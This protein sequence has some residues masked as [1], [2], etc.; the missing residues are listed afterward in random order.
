M[1]SPREGGKAGRLQA[2]KI[3][4]M[5]RGGHYVPG[6]PRPGIKGGVCPVIPDRC[7]AIT[8]S[9]EILGAG[10]EDSTGVHIKKLAN[11]G[12][13]EHLLVLRSGHCVYQEG[14]GCS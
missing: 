11:K 10:M 5:V 14:E 8:M 7:L 3:S 9:G 12:L 2:Q 6:H 13:Q 4:V 1:V